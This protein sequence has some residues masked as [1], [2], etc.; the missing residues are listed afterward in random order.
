M[1]YIPELVALTACVYALGL[2]LYILVYRTQHLK[3]GAGQFYRLHLVEGSVRLYRLLLL[4]YPAPF[5]MEYGPAMIQLFRDTARDSFCRRGLPGL[6]AAWLWTLADFSTS[7]VR[8]HGDNATAMGSE[9]LLLRDLLRQWGQLGSAALSVTSVS[10]WYILHVLH[11]YFRRAAL[12]WATLTALAFT[13]W[14][15]SLFESFTVRHPLPSVFINRGVV[16][17]YHA[18]EVG[19]PISDEQWQRETR[20]WVE[21]NPAVRKRL[22]EG[23]RPWAFRFI[24][25]IPGCRVLRHGPDFKPIIV[26]PY[27]EWQLCFP[28]ILV[29]LLLLGGTIL[30]YRRGHAV[31]AAAVQSA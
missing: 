10:T 3:E 5:R 15:A 29:P 12:V 31:A 18:Y 19:D 17:I 1:S 22:T 7:V 23:P 8:Q 9:S 24:S 20:E 11:L 25:D 28:F 30:A 6:L 26:Q 2:L 14:L 4:A 21:Q 16:M 13:I 27:R